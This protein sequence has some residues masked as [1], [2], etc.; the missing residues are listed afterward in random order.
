MK[1]SNWRKWLSEL[2]RHVVYQLI[3]AFPLAYFISIA[4]D[5]ARG[6]A[7]AFDSLSP[8]FW[9]IVATLALTFLIRPAFVV[10]LLN[11]WR[12]PSALR[13]ELD[14]AYLHIVYVLEPNTVPIE[15]RLIN[16]PLAY[17]VV[18]QD[19]IDLLR[20]KL[21]KR[22][23]DEVPD[24]IIVDHQHSVLQWHDFLRNIRTRIK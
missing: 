20:P 10:P 1:F 24:Q 14:D 17:R 2:G 22:F 13:R 23:P 11:W 8:L 12:Q 9:P 15:R 4:I 3:S 21:I 5:A 18:A 6:A 7:V 16:D 19:K